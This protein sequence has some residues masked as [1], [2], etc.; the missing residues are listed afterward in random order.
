LR[1]PSAL[2]PG[3]EAIPAEKAKAFRE[4]TQKSLDPEPQ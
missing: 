3:L 1:N 4:F 2:K